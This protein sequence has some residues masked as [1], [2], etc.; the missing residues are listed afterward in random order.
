MD[1]IPS[2]HRRLRKG[3][4]SPEFERYTFQWLIPVPCKDGD[5]MATVWKKVINVTA[6]FSKLITQIPKPSG[7]LLTMFVEFYLQTL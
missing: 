6:A 3:F 2:W 5:M 4:Y 7:P 1:D